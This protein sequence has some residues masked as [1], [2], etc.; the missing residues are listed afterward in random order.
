MGEVTFLGKDDKGRKSHITDPPDLEKKHYY[1]LSEPGIAIEHANRDQARCGNG[2]GGNEQAVQG[3]NIQFM[4]Y[5][6][7]K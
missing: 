2:R 3:G 1:E 5:G 6:E 4:G 7:A